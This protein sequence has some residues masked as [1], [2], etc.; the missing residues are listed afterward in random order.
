M[1]S[2]RK[3]TAVPMVGSKKL[4]TCRTKNVQE[5]LKSRLLAKTNFFI[6]LLEYIFELSNYEIQF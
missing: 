5:K 3:N 2:K 6:I 4:R 1:P